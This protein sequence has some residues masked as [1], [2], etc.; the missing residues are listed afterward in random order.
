MHINKA[1]RN[2]ISER[3]RRRQLPA[4]RR[5]GAGGEEE[6]RDLRKER[7]AHFVSGLVSSP[8]RLIKLPL[9]N[10]RQESRHPRR[11][12]SEIPP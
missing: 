2:Q 11:I 9:V 7:W 12:Q 5:N 1:M 3:R 4:G 8:I 10:A 6:E